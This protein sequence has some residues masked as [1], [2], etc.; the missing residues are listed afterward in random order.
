MVL[1]EWHLRLTS[2]LYI[3]RTYMCICMHSY[4]NMHTHR[5][6]GTNKK[7]SREREAF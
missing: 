2:G 4:R 6:R 1:K 5:H 7:G 3:H